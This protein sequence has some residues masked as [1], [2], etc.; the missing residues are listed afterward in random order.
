MAVPKCKVSKARRNSRNSANRLLLNE[1]LIRIGSQGVQVLLRNIDKEKLA[2]ALK[3]SS[4]SIKELFFN[5]MSSR[6]GKI[7]KEGAKIVICGQVQ[8]KTEQNIY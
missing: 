6:A 8:I 5:N 2:I 7:I 3:S 1:D 4:D